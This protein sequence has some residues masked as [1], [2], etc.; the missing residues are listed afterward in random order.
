MAKSKVNNK[1]TRYLSERKRI[2]NKTRKLAKLTRNLSPE[3]RDKILK[4]C[5]IGRMKEKK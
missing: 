3:T 2:K 5:P 4:A 1:C